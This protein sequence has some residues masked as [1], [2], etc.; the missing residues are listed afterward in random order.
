ML[1]FKGFEIFYDE[2]DNEWRCEIL[3]IVKDGLKKVKDAITKQLAAELKAEPIECYH[4]SWRHNNVPQTVMITSFT[5]D[6]KFAW[7]RD[8]RG[9]EKHF[10]HDLY[11][12][13]PQNK[14]ILDKAVELHRQIDVLRGQISE[15]EKGL[16][17]VESPF[18][19]DNKEQE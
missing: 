15:M 18:N 2:S 17:Y 19:N 13:T 1:K 3:G 4:V 10:C 6:G 16:E 8:E 12:H 9:R 11:K 7:V 5:E 14:S